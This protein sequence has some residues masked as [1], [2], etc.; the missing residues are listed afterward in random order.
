MTH[1]DKIKVVNYLKSIDVKKMEFFEEMYDHIVTSYQS[2]LNKSESINEHITHVIQPGFGGVKGIKRVMKSQ[3]KLR[4]QIISKR[5]W[6]L[7]K[8]YLLKWPTVLTTVLITLIVYQLNLLFRPKDVLL[9]IM[10]F[11]VLVPVLVVLTGQARFY[12]QCKIQGRPYSSSDLN[13]RLLLLAAFG[14]NLVNI[15]LNLVANVIWGAQKNGLE[16]MASYPVVQISLSVLFILYA[17]VMIQLLKE[18]FIFR[19]AI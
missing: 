17:L 7:F 1:E 5:A 15:L 2:R 13:A 9:V 16:M 3:Q 10:S 19:I 4:Q 8:S 14:T 6:N 11:S 12:R 18:K